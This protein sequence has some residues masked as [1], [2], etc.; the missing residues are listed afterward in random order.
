MTNKKFSTL[1]M[2]ELA[3]LTAVVLVLQLTGTA[4]KIPVLG[5]SVSLVL[6]PIVL[7]A[8]MIGPL[9][10]AWLGFVF[11]IVV[12]TVGAM[13]MDPFTNIMFTD[14][15]I[16]TFLICT[17]KGSLAGLFAGL[18]YKALGNKNKF[19]SVFL[20]SAVAPITNTGLFV[21][22]SLVMADT[23]SKNAE[24]FEAFGFAEGMSL[25]YYLVIV[26]AGIN[27]IFELLLN[28]VASPVIIRVS[29]AVGKV[30]GKKNKA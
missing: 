18:V 3:L 4:I 27:F 12:F 23:F 11:G 9:A 26:I 22:G 6:I 28:I 1:K 14:N 24:Q 19:A 17:L 29:D 21:L 15:P 5:T 10:G 30:L 16:M 8:V 25:F 7:G 20:A 2:V 13:G